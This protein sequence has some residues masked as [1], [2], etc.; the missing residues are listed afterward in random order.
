MT[1][2]NTGEPGK[3]GMSPSDPS[4]HEVAIQPLLAQSREN[5]D[6]LGEALI[7]SVFVLVQQQLAED[8]VRLQEFNKEPLK[9]DADVKLFVDPDPIH[10][11]LQE[12]EP[13]SSLSIVLEPMEDLSKLWASF[14]GDETPS[15]AQLEDIDDA[16]E[17]TIAAGR[18]RLKIYMPVAPDYIYPNPLKGNAEGEEDSAEDED[19]PPDIMLEYEHDVTAESGE[20]ERYIIRRNEHT[21]R[22]EV[23][24]LLESVTET[25]RQVI[26]GE[27]I[28]PEML[29][30]RFSETLSTQGRTMERVARWV[31]N[32]RPVEQ[33]EVLQR[34]GVIE[35]RHI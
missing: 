12:G 30:R 2:P 1:S 9:G 10:Y 13:Q 26:E 21:G 6:K 18:D 5:I 20:Y 29:L 8:A 7:E 14:N 3:P 32:F 25:G 17:L 22:F 27:E 33:V 19:V 24:E 35:R 28:T 16:I 11:P 34:D 31:A 4:Q 15:R 23:V